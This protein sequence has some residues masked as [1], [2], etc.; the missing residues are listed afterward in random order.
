M[1]KS[2][3]RLS[4]R[5]NNYLGWN[6][7]RSKIIFWRCSFSA[8]RRWFI[9]CWDFRSVAASEERFNDFRFNARCYSDVV[10]ALPGIYFQSPSWITRISSFHHL[11][12][13]KSLR[14]AFRLMK[15]LTNH[16][17]FVIFHA[18]SSAR[19]VSSRL[20]SDLSVYFSITSNNNLPW[21][22]AFHKATRLLMRGIRVSQPETKVRMRLSKDHGSRSINTWARCFEHESP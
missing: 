4:D 18:S 22:M 2:N 16:L 17:P 6:S 11:R 21:L 1:L 13:S 15:I 8:S 7:I 19:N 14:S 12:P 5:S 3:H 20:R 9:M 10:G